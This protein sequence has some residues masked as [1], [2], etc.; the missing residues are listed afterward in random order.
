[1]SAGLLLQTPIRFMRLG[2]R[3]LQ[4][5]IIYNRVEGR[6]SRIVSNS[7]DNTNTMYPRKGLDFSHECN[8]INILECFL[9]MKFLLCITTCTILEYEVQKRSC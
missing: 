5:Y 1:M 7:T 8:T 3:N 9:L 2:C 4:V 6:H